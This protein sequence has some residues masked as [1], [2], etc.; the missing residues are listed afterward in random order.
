M[1]FCCMAEILAACRTRVDAAEV[2]QSLLPVP[3]S[4]H[5]RERLCYQWLLTDA[6]QS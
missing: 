3:F 4:L 5:W 6:P 1:R 2:A